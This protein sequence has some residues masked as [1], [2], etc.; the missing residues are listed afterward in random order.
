[1]TVLHHLEFPCNHKLEIR[2]FRAHF[3]FC[4][5]KISNKFHKG[6]LRIWNQHDDGASKYATSLPLQV[7]VCFFQQKKHRRKCL[8]LFTHNTVQWYNEKMITWLAE[9]AKCS[10]IILNKSSSGYASGPML[11]SSVPQIHQ[12]VRSNAHKQHCWQRKLQFT[13]NCQI[14][15]VI[16]NWVTY[17]INRFRINATKTWTVFKF[18][19]VGLRYNFMLLFSWIL[20]VNTCKK[21]IKFV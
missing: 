17:N 7:S 8:L 6:N 4:S 9:M 19:I 14:L 16:N 5:W 13:Y 15:G 21:V 3:F 2:G 20:H 11:K 1:M 12:L 10:Y 18:A